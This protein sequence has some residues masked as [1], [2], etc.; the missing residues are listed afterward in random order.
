MLKILTLP[1][2]I[3]SYYFCMV[4]NYLGYHVSTPIIKKLMKIETNLLSW[5]LPIMSWTTCLK[6]W[7]RCFV[8][9]GSGPVCLSWC[10]SCPCLG[11][12]RSVANSKIVTPR[13]KISAALVNFLSPSTSVAKYLKC[14]KV[15]N[16]NKIILSRFWRKMYRVN[17]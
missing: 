10:Q 1:K 7:L 3:K 17:I 6:S 5:S 9:W 15:V 12:S 11:K 13:A 4:K 14:I 8:N 2:T 16:G